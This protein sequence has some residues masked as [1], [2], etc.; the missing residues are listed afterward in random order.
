MGNKEE[1]EEGENK[2]EEVS[3]EKKQEEKERRR[4]VKNDYFQKL[5]PTGSGRRSKR[6]LGSVVWR[7][8][9]G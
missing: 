6:F 9:L 2:K 5:A 3:E 1:E 7:P 4:A 8:F